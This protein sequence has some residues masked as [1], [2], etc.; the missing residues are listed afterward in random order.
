MEPSEGADG[1]GGGGGACGIVSFSVSAGDAY[2]VT[3]GSGGTVG[4]AS[5][6]TVGIWWQWRDDLSLQ[7]PQDAWSAT[8]G[9]GGGSALANGITIEPNGT[10]GAG[11]SLRLPVQV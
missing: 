9:T 8:G 11:A 1:G 5:N 6:T 2:S 4:P 10:G 7:D 3:V